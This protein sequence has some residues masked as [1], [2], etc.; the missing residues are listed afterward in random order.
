MFGY[1]PSV[2]E[3]FQKLIRSPI[4]FF[5]LELSLCTCVCIVISASALKSNIR[6]KKNLAQRD[7][8]SGR[9]WVITLVLGQGQQ[10]VTHH[11]LRPY[12]AD[13]IYVLK[14]E[15][16]HRSSWSIIIPLLLRIEMNNK[17]LIWS[18][19]SQK[20]LLPWGRGA[21][22]PAAV[23]DGQA[24]WSSLKGHCQQS[25]GNDG[26]PASVPLSPAQ[27]GPAPHTPSGPQ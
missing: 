6:V 3:Y 22:G 11:S 20:C 7:W 2:K 8:N 21:G 14:T 12:P 19:K 16:G 13:L 10:S 5:C 15:Q 26:W 27:A 24:L 4:Y 1:A 18:C 25:D 23:C 9:V 17:T